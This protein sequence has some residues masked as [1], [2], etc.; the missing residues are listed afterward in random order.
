M[1]RFAEEILLLLLD[2]D[3]GGL[4]Q[5]PDQL[6]GYVLA[7]SV[8]MNLA[9]ENRIDTDLDQL[10]LLDATPTGDTLLD[11]TL[12]AIAQ[13][14]G[15]HNIDH[16]VQRLAQQAEDIRGEAFR[17]LVAHGILEDDDS[18]LFSLTR[19]VSRTRRYPIIDGKAG[20]EVKLRIMGIIFTDDIP[21]PHDIVI[22]TLA[23]A[24]GIF[25]RILSNAELA[26]VQARITLIS[27]LDL[28]GQSVIRAIQQLDAQNG[29]RRATPRSPARSWPRVPGLPVLGNAIALRGDMGAFV[30][31]QYHKHGPIFEVTS[32]GRR[33]VVLAGPEA[34]IF[35]QHHGKT[36]LRSRDIWKS[37]MAEWGLSKLIIGADDDEH[38]RLR[39]VMKESFS[40]GNYEYHIATA[41]DCTEREINTWPLGKSLP[42]TYMLQR[43]VLSQ[44][45]VL[46]ARIEPGAYLN[47]LV[48]LFNALLRAR[49]SAHHSA[50][51][52]KLPHI[53]RARRRVHELGHRILADHQ[54][55]D[56]DHDRHDFVDDMLEAHRMSPQFV[57]E[58]DLL[59]AALS[60]FLVGLETAAVTGSFTLYALLKYPDLTARAREE[61]AAIFANGV[62]TA[63]DLRGVDIIKRTAME[64]MRMWP[65]FPGVLRTVANSF[66]F[67]GYT[68]PAGT[69]IFLATSIP[70]HLPHLFPDPKRFDINRY[71]PER[72]EH[73][74]RGAY[75]PFG[76]G[77]HRCLGG[78]FA[79]AQLALTLAALLY[80]TE[81]V[82]DPPGYDLKVKTA[83]SARPDDKFK[84]K[85]LRRESPFSALDKRL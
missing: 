6:L 14:A 30:L 57:P 45:G 53:Q 10:M 64:A 17:R 82:L 83:P 66:E 48:T 68:V 21:S 43:I 85:V 34:N 20:Q 77:P 12:A 67:Q 39:R 58:T 44:L 72:S 2:E 15:A 79:E 38:F 16:W 9:I 42:A 54:R 3:T 18:G 78:G 29:P 11:P 65:V 61:A 7:G 52:L 26:Q 13:D 74:Q 55:K 19:W 51:R 76:L 81:L 71:T 23:N 69:Q 35:A 63:Q 50:L 32:V 84:F 73:R 22:I 27:Q 70:H 60:P 59:F 1:L 5:I 8:L 40:V 36:H 31:K 56:R 49:I 62:P 24:C 41:L 33:F 4:T 47:D 25:D 46:L 37:F 80:K 28:I 75:A